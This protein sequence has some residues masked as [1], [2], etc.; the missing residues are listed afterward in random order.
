MR[1]TTPRGSHSH[2]SLHWTIYHSLHL[3][4]RTNVYQRMRAISIPKC[5]GLGS[6]FSMTMRLIAA[7]SNIECP[8][9]KYSIE[10]GSRTTSLDEQN[11]LD[12]CWRNGLDTPCS[13]CSEPFD[14]AVAPPVRTLRLPHRSLADSP[15]TNVLPPIK[16]TNTHLRC[17]KENNIKFIPVSHAWHDPVARAYASRE[18][19]TEAARMI[20]ELPV[21]VLLAAIHRFGPDVQIWHD[22]ISIPQWQE[23]FRGTTI[24]PQIFQIFKYGGTAL[25]HLDDEP[26]FDLFAIFS[27]Q[28]ILL[29]ATNL[30]RIFDAR[31]FRRMWIIVEFLMCRDGYL[32]NSRYEIMSN[33]FSIFMKAITEHNLRHLSR[34]VPLIPTLEWMSSIPL[35]S[36]DTSTHNC[37]GHVFDLLA[38]QGC[39]SH[40]DRFI[41]TCAI[42]EQD[43]NSNSMAELPQNTQEACLYVAKRA[44]Q[45]NDW[46]P[47]LLRPSDEP[48]YPT[49]QWL[50][51]HT[52]MEADMWGLGIRTSAAQSTPTILPDNSVEIAVQYLG[53]IWSSVPIELLDMSTV[54]SAQCTQC[55]MVTPCQAYMWYLPSGEAGLYRVP[56][57]CY[58]TT[59]RSHA[60]LVFENGRILG[61]AY[62]YQGWCRCEGVVKLRVV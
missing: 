62:F 31:W 61:R 22:Y 43:E 36:R 46:S 25:I 52:A 45:R 34:D 54:L 59:G 6:F 50:K 40:R 16:I 41:A 28:D 5:C 1:P 23:S 9:P 30:R 42:L 37:L 57:L 17:L 38:T 4:A 24:L 51:G 53:Q 13:I 49:V 20:F 8:D 12:I 33:T 29:H 19:N 55:R 35:F 21:R 44:L 7:Q 48:P 18:S 60:G 32:M 58:E 47:L 14:I 15:T 10:I 39:R 26:T 56:D 2:R 3:G 11:L 27:R